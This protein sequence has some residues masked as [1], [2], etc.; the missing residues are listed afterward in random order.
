MVDYLRNHHNI[1]LLSN[2][3]FAYILS[4][5]GSS[6]LHHMYEISVI[7]PVLDTVVVSIFVVEEISSTIN[8]TVSSPTPS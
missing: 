4:K 8:V 7:P 2:R 1:H 6:I 3:D 5:K